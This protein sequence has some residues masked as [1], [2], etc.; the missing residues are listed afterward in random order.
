VGRQMALVKIPRRSSVTSAA[1]RA[2]RR[3]AR[4]WIAARGWTT[5]KGGVECCNA[6]TSVVHSAAEGAMVP[7][8]NA[9]RP[10]L[11]VCLDCI[12]YPTAPIR[13]HEKWTTD[14]ETGRGLVNVTC[15]R[16]SRTMRTRGG[17]YY[18]G[19]PFCWD[20][21]APPDDIFNAWIIA[22]RTDPNAARPWLGDKAAPR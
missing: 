5:W 8:G 7:S 18:R 21:G 1:T 22:L 15:A 6:H 13:G 3:E 14:T 12:P 16:C 4:A 17:M 19:G 20:C 10:L 9:A 2:A 11:A